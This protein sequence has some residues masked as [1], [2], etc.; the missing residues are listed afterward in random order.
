MLTDFWE[1]HIASIFRACSASSLLRAG[2]LL[3]FL[4]DPEYG[5]DMF[6]RNVD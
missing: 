1:K 4:F 3:G 2:F 6:L 5:D